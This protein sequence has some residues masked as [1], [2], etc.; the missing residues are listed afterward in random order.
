MLVCNLVTEL[1]VRICIYTY[2]HTYSILDLHQGVNTSDHL[3]VHEIL[4]YI[5][6]TLAVLNQRSVR[7]R[8]EP[9]RWS[10]L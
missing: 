9:F 7:T 5:N 6:Q 2:I 4:A 1:Y 8:H 3:P 10:L